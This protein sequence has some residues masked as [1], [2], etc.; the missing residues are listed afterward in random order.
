MNTVTPG[1]ATGATDP[2]LPQAA[3]RIEQ[4]RFSGQLPFLYPISRLQREF[5]IGYS[6]TRALVDA[7]AQCG[8]WTIAFTA[9]GS[10]Y[11]RLERKEAP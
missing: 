6:R 4:L 10:R 9:D 2:L 1:T 11:A 7:L 8:E 5:R 3:A